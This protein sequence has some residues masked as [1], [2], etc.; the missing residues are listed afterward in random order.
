MINQNRLSRMLGAKPW[1]CLVIQRMM[2][3]KYG[4]NGHSSRRQMIKYRVEE[5]DR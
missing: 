3:K 4:W 1:D 2:R 5:T